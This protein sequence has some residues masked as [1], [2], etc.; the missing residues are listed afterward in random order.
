MGYLPEMI[1][2]KSSI[3]LA[4][5]DQL[6]SDEKEDIMR[7]VYND[8][9]VKKLTNIARQEWKHKKGDM[10]SLYCVAMAVGTIIKEYDWGMRFVR[11]DGL[12]ELA[13]RILDN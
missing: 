7:C 11:S 9:V 4:V 6:T 2:Y 12:F 5:I 8:N 10:A 3:Q 13:K 1:A